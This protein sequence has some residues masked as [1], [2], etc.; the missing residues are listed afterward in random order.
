[1]TGLQQQG[2]LVIDEPAS[3]TARIVHAECNQHDGAQQQSKV[4][5]YRGIPEAVDAQV[6][7]IAKE[8]KVPMGEVMRV[9]LEYALTAYEA[10]EMLLNPQPRIVRS[11]RNKTLFPDS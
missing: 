10:G 9:L 11:E 6:K 3:T 8:M 7:T 5:S 4:R 2:W 1:M